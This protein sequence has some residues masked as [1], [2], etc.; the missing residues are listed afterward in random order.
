MVTSRARSAVA[1]AIL[2]A[3]TALLSGTAARAQVKGP[4]GSEN[5][6][7][8][9]A[10]ETTLRTA[11]SYSSHEER[12]SAEAVRTA[13]RITVDGR[14]DEPAWM[15]APPV[16]EFWQV[17][18][19]EGSPITEP[20]EVRFLYDDDAIYVGA[21]L[22]DNDGTIVSRM[23]RRDT[24]IP[25]IDLFAVHF[26]SY[27]SHRSS[28]RFTVAASGAIRDLAAGANDGLTGGDRSWNPVWEVRTTV[29]PG[30]WYAEM[31]IPFSQLRFSRDEEQT[32][33]L[34]IE[35]KIRPSQEN[36]I[37]SFTLKDQPQGK[38]TFGHLTGLRGIKPGR[39]LEL[40]PY[41]G[42]SAEYT[43]VPRNSNA[44]F[45][46][47]FRS[48]SDYFGNG[49]L[50]LKYR[51]TSNLTLD[52]T[53][54]PDFGQVEVDPAVI[55]LTAFET[56]FSER[57][58]FFVEGAEI[59]EFGEDAPEI[60]YSRRIGRQPHGTVPGE[61]VYDLTPS[62]TTILGAAKL[63][64]KSASGWS[65]AALNAVTAREQ[66]Y[67]RDIQDTEDRI[68]VEPLT[69]YFAGR[70]RREMRGGQTAIGALVT[71]VHR[72][73]SSSP[74]QGK[75][76]TSAYSGGLDFSHDFEDREWHVSGSFSPSY[77]SGSSESL[78]A[79]QRSSSRYYQ[80]PDADYLGVD[81][82]ATSLFGYSAQAGLRKQAG[83]WRF[84]VS[85]SAHSPGYEVNDIGF[86]RRVDRIGTQ[87]DFG[88]NQTR[89]GRYTRNWNVTVAPRLAWNY[90]GDLIDASTTISTRAQLHNFARVTG[91]FSYNPAKMNQRLTRG[92]PLTRDP[93]G[94]SGSLNYSTV[95]QASV[96]WRLGARYGRDRSGA[97]QRGTNFSLNFRAGEM[98]DMSIGP[99]FDQNRRTAQYITSV[100]DATATQTFGRR[101]V[102]ADLDQ[103]TL[104]INTRINITLSP[105]TTIEIFAQPFLS[106]GNYENL[107]ELA[108]PKTFD[109]NRY[110]SG[111]GTIAA[112]D[113]QRH[114]QID[115]DGVVGPAQQFQVDNK[116][117]NVRSLIANAVFRWEWK[118]GSTLFLVWQ[119]S[120]S[121]RVAA[122]DPDSPYARVGNFQL[123]RDAGD[124]FGLSA[125]NI[126]LIKASYWLNP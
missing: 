59:F 18:P 66:A 13:D 117:F 79:T 36:T 87:A 126:L 8:A 42:G 7:A 22:Y 91:R 97:W 48:G 58:P 28:Y 37:W 84:E 106:S 21:W 93:H 121:G 78:V 115:P 16:T 12:P 76:H 63:S 116:D 70:A 110:G 29:T 9:G 17:D 11:P 102:F 57:R 92:G 108:T 112:V 50:D 105:R 104:S 53:V 31:R 33:G 89:P 24:G 114:F 4:G 88:Y 85:G 56:R 44:S 107:K 55:N 67:W 77:V 64:G 5:P 32:W 25:D 6:P 10:P 75:I 35:R 51:L 86:M 81:S 83:L 26:D 62:A 54:N 41:V 15:T 65:L 47:P 111:A 119:Q 96:T 46:N 14:L 52:G 27:H 73:L 23:A 122:S 71:T 30:G 40:L 39:P 61:A 34:Q 113:G 68:E 43:T 125:D 95:N 74:L 20:T 123:G 120:R 38:L 2:A 100:T 60:L 80:R 98:F 72:N 99:S 101:Y 3:A 94:Y 90:G 109:F 124:L 45:D 19:D 1:T 118:P 69:N 82:T 49:G 103:S